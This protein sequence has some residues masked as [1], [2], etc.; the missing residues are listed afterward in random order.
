MI[1]AWTDFNNS[2]EKRFVADVTVY[3]CGSI[4]QIY[5]SSIHVIFLINSNMVF[6]N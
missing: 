1:T 6:I 3:K 5:S 2:Q 4:E